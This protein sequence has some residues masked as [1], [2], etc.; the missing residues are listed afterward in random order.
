MEATLQF[1]SSVK[2]NE[3]L[4]FGPYTYPEIVN[5]I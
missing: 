1:A 2:E 3:K 5:L 4:S